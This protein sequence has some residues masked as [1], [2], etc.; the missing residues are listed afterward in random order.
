MKIQASTYYIRRYK[1]IIKNNPQLN[2]KVKGKLWLAINDLNHPSLRL[3]KITGRFD[4]VWSISIDMNIRVIFK[5][6][7][8]LMNLLDIGTHEDIY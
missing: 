3:H 1:K 6:K 8:D 7:G 4:N 2:S 5:L